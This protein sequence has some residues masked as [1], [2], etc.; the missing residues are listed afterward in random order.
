[1]VSVLPLRRTDTRAVFI[2]ADDIFVADLL[3]VLSGHTA[4]L[5]ARSDHG[6]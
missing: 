4:H 3:A 5:D 1:M 6:F 2:G